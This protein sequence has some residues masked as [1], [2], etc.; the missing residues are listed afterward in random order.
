MNEI[1]KKLWLACSKVRFL[2]L[3]LKRRVRLEVGLDGRHLTF[4]LTALGEAGYGVHV[5]GA[6][7]VFRELMLLRKSVP[8]PFV[9]GGKERDCGI[10]ISDRPST[11]DSGLSTLFLLDYDYFSGLLERVEP[12]IA[13]INSDREP[14]N[15]RI[16]TKGGNQL[17]ESAVFL[18]DQSLAGL[19]M[20]NQK[21]RT[22][23][24]AN[25][26][27]SSGENS[28][29]VSISVM[30]GQNSSSPATSH[31]LPDTAPQALRMPYFMHPS[32][33]HKGLHKRVSATRH[34]PQRRRRFRIGFFGTHDREFYT[35]H[36][37][38]P[39]M[40]RF[41]ILEVFLQKF[42]DRIT[43]LRGFPRDW[44]S[45]EVAVS[46][47]SRGGDRKG[48]S[49]LTQDHYFE[50]LRECDFILS[51]PG[52][53]MSISHNLIEAMFCGAV[54]ITN[55]GAFMAEPLRDSETCLEFQ[56]P[57]DL[58]SVIERVLAMDESEVA[59]MRNAVNNYYNR[60]LEPKAFVET[61]IRGNS[62]QIFVNAEEHSVPFYHSNTQ[63][64]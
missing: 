55:G 31:S 21:D 11:L 45:C 54:P 13:R 38:F 6:P 56:N 18:E 43:P 61:F 29:S 23:R 41:E 20:D 52:W 5:V 39:G 59:R 28:S 10:W 3:P 64:N 22:I 27:S 33:Y 35:R 42:G 50:A 32:V 14:R 24:A 16:D 34:S 30:S 37:H 63:C 62:K 36:Y 53:C 7:F 57:D 15:T 40:N 26:P 47:D 46:I 44:D 51:P 19:H 8:M 17:A 48:K 58:F 9:I 25:D 49:F 12:R 60:F 1:Q 4:L 2:R